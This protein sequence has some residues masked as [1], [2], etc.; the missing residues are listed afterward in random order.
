MGDKDIL[1]KKTKSEKDLKTILDMILNNPDTLDYCRSENVDYDE[2][3]AHL[4]EHPEYISNLTHNVNIMDKEIHFRKIAEEVINDMRSNL[5]LLNPPLPRD[6]LDTFDRPP[7]FLYKYIRWNHAADNLA[8]KKFSCG[9]VSDYRV[10][11]EDEVNP[12]KI[13]KIKSGYE[14]KIIANVLSDTI[15]P[16]LIDYDEFENNLD[17]KLNSNFLIGCFSD[18]PND[19]ML[20]KVR[21]CDYGVCI[22]IRPRPTDC[23]IRIL[24][25][26]YICDYSKLK[27][28]FKNLT[29]SMKMG[30]VPDIDNQFNN[31]KKTWI[32]L[33]LMT[34]FRKNRCWEFESEWRIILKGVKGN[35]TK[36]HLQKL[37]PIERV[38]GRLSE[39]DAA[40]M[41]NVCKKIHVKFTNKLT[42]RPDYL[43]DSVPNQP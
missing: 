19:D 18:K 21:A 31:L 37:P 27:E 15:P 43:D 14:E 20:W 17:N 12:E 38:E 22:V 36:P 42:P 41:Q 2:L 9:T 1:F 4:E 33:S 40:I 32:T 24:Y 3:R 25:R 11:D 7:Q 8:I 35:R 23:F 10:D 39:E 5:S 30:I 29:N 34:I 13:A 26:D 28:S 16:N 6:Y